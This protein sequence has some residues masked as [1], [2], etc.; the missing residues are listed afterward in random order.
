MIENKQ[1]QR[2]KKEKLQVDK[3]K[4]AFNDMIYNGM[5]VELETS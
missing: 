2:F 4:N 5:S 3:E 1:K